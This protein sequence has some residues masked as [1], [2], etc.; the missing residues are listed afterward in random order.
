MLTLSPTEKD[1]PRPA[2]YGGCE[3]DPDERAEC[4]ILSRGDGGGEVKAKGDK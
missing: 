3:T 1:Y 4:G 2:T